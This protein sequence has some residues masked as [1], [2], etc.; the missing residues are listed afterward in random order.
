MTLP[1]LLLAALL[2]TTHGALVQ[3]VRADTV[4][5]PGAEVSV[6][7]L[8]ELMRLEELFAVLRDEGIQNGRDLADTMFPD[9]GGA[10]WNADL[11]RIYDANAL[12]ARFD[13]VLE[14]DLG[15]D[16]IAMK[17]VVDFYGSDLG[18]RI[19]G[20]E[21]EARRTF[22]DAAAEE[23]AQVAADD[24]ASAKDPR[25]ALIRRMIEACD[26]LEMNV[27]GSMSSSLAFSQGMV[28]SGGYGATLPPD[29]LTS[30]AW[31]QEEQTRADLSSWLYSYLGLAYAPLS[32]AELTRYV[33]FW[34]SP[35]GQRLNA[36]LFKG[37]D[38]VFR[39]V[40][41]DLGRAAGKA[42]QGLDI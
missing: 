40:S 27:A 21:I 34:E 25:V 33:E 4:Q 3:P 13:A 41:E 23:A 17:G 31:A 26:L 24:A 16:P 1:R 12:R 14:Q 30:D 9:G 18:Q 15:A 2:A 20:L 42:M 32:E 7:R 19:L 35:A 36:A 28:E 39:P 10:G 5:L 8:S 38:A 29:Q 11:A 37:F 6:E 22:L